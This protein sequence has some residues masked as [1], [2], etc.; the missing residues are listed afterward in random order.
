MGIFCRLRYG[1]L[2]S[3]TASRSGRQLDPWLGGTQLV[4]DAGSLRAASLQRQ[5]L[6][7][8]LFAC[9]VQLEPVHVCEGLAEAFR[10]S[11]CNLTAL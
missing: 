8:G 11:N 10:R 5:A 9:P 7:V 3:T 2:L 6:P 4:S 1:A